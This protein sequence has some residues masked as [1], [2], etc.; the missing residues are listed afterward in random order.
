MDK[1]GELPQSV[2]RKD[3][4]DQ[5]FAHN[6]ITQTVTLTSGAHC[7]NHTLENS[8][9]D[10]LSNS[11]KIVFSDS[12]NLLKIDLTKF[13]SIFDVDGVG[14]PSITGGG[15]VLYYK[16]NKLFLHGKYT[17]ATYK[18]FSNIGTIEFLAGLPYKVIMWDQ[19][20]K[21][22]GV[23]ING[24]SIPNAAFN[25]TRDETNKSGYIQRQNTLSD[26]TIGVLSLNVSKDITF[27]HKEISILATCS[28][29]NSF[30]KYCNYQTVDSINPDNS[31]V[32]TTYKNNTYVFC[33]STC[34]FNYKIYLD[35]LVER[36]YTTKEYVDSRTPLIVISSDEPTNKVENMI[37][38]K[39]I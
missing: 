9:I 24:T 36:D 18:A 16:D 13:T 30:T 37:W 32:I 1:Q 28:E 27:E 22:L 20:T 31:G 35:N 17:T 11:G 14:Y 23:T 25:I 5:Y 7:I 3:Y 8:P 6:L 38:I 2:V 29:G 39:P 10:I 15:L 34:S 33:S 19:E 21:G 26:N 4:V 12:Y